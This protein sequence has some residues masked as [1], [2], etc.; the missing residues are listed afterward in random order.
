MFVNVPLIIYKELEQ[1]TSLPVVCSKKW[2]SALL[3]PINYLFLF[4]LSQS[5]FNSFQ[6]SFGSK[7][8][9]KM[10][11]GLL[12]HH[13]DHTEFIRMRGPHGKGF[14]QMAVR[15]YSQNENEASVRGNQQW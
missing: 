2:I 6:S 9:Q 5:I 1:R 12:S 13:E 3:T 7:M 8:V 11:L 4:Y 10:T 15:L 14:A